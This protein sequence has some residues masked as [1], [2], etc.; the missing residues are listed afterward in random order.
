LV[1]AGVPARPIQSE[2]RLRI[3]RNPSR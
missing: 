3:M 1:V 2:A